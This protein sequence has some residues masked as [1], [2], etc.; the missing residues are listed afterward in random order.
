MDLFPSS[1]E[2][3]ETPTLLGTLEGATLNQPEDENRSSFR[4]V[5]FSSHLEFRT[6]EKK[7]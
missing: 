7:P 5:V 2:R 6:T 3:R 1:G 4:N